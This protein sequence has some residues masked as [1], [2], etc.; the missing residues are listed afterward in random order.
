MKTQLENIYNLA[1]ADI[2]K[3]TSIADIE[4]VKL[5]YLSRKGEFNSIKKGLKD[6]SDEEKRTI[7]AFANQITE[8]LETELKSK[9]D[10]FYRQEMNEKL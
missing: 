8:E 2:E 10:L 7:G 5:K 3:V 9:Y 6:L 4:D 1:K